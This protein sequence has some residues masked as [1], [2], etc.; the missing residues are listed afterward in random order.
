MHCE[1][2]VSAKRKV[3]VRT[4][5]GLMMREVDEDESE[6]SAILDTRD[7]LNK[8]SYNWNAR[9]HSILVSIPGGK[10]V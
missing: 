2:V 1:T 3:W 9:K 10:N 6:I 4:S 7:R 5:S 8:A